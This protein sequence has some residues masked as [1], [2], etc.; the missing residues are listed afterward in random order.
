MRENPSSRQFNFFSETKVAGPEKHREV[1]R[2][3][4]SYLTTED[5]R[6]IERHTGF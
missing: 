4:V 3:K 6:D 1:T 2:R 5:Y